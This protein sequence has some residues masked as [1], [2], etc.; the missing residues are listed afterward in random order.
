MF[1]QSG[2]VRRFDPERR[3]RVGSS[4]YKKG[5]EVR[6]VLTSEEEL[7]EA[8]RLLE[9]VGLRPGKPFRKNSRFVQPI[10]GR[11]ALDWF[12]KRAG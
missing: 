12:L 3:K 11:S 10:Y 7:R 2:Y 5:F 8:R 9:V 1:E 6:L 4:L